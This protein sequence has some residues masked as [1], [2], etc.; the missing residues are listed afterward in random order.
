[1]NKLL[2]HPH[3]QRPYSKRALA[4][5]ICDG[6]TSAEAA[7]ILGRKLRFI[8]AEQRTADYQRLFQN[9]CDARDRRGVGAGVD[10][11]R[12]YSSQMEPP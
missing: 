5:L 10:D 6:H 1:M 11:E 8:E 12:F 2:I 4:Q 3:A 9:L 7:D